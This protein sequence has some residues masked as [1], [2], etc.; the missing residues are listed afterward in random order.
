M[1][2]TDLREIA[3]ASGIQHAEFCQEQLTTQIGRDVA[4]PL[5]LEMSR[6]VVEYADANDGVGDLPDIVEG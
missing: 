1:T 5:W 3:A 4:E 2:I 6:L